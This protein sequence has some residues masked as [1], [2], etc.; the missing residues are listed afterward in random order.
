MYTTIARLYTYPPNFF[1]TSLWDQAQ[2]YL[3]IHG[4]RLHAQQKDVMLGKNYGESV[5]RSKVRVCAENFNDC[6]EA[7]L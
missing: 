2:T 5:V 3:A 1:I 6:A 4:E 7:Y